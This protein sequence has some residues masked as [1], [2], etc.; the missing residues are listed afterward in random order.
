VAI[1]DHLKEKSMAK[2]KP[3]RKDQ[4]HLLPSCLEDYVPA[5]LSKLEAGIKSDD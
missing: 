3:Y 5:V 2:F 1:D 4:L